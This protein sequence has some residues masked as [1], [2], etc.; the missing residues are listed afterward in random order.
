MEILE[1]DETKREI[2]LAQKLTER[3]LK[4]WKENEQAY[5][6]FFM[7]TGACRYRMQCKRLHIVPLAAETILIDHMYK[8]AYGKMKGASK[9]IDDS[10]I[11]VDEAAMQKAYEEFYDDVFPEWSKFGKIVQFKCCNN[12]QQHLRGSVYIQYETVEAAILARLSLDG[13]FYAGHPLK[14]SFSLIKDWKQAICAYNGPD[15]ASC[16]KFSECNFLHVY[17]NPRG[18]FPLE[19]RSHERERRPR[20]GRGGFDRGGGFRGGFNRGGFRRDGS[21]SPQRHH[22]H[23]RPD[24][25]ESRHDRNDRHDRHERKRSRSKERRHSRSRSKERRHSRSRD[26]K[27]HKKRDR[28]SRSR[29]HERKHKKSEHKRRSRSRD[30]K[31]SHSR[32]RKRK[33][34]RS[35]S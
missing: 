10:L 4:L 35:R 18:E 6:T 23:H 24:R 19:R 14:V 32:D 34:S 2:Y 22:H 25:H 16:P 27:E 8:D 15:M 7:K 21:R 12:I 30:R 31:R 1:L 5:C 3:H 11:E 26:R 13:R 28:S 17:M 29:S 9:G 20:G 33:H